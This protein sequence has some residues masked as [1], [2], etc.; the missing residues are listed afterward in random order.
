MPVWCTNKNYYTVYGLKLTIDQEKYNETHKQY[1]SMLSFLN[2][3]SK[4]PNNLDKNKYKL[5]DDNVLESSTNYQ[6]LD[7][8]LNKKMIHY[9]GKSDNIITKLA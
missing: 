1:D 9:S 4:Q 3:I 8:Y 6:S 5:K 7:Y 2:R